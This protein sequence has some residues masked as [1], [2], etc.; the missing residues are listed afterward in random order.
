MGH[1]ATIIYRTKFKELGVTSVPLKYEVS[2]NVDMRSLDMTSALE[3]GFEMFWNSP[4]LQDGATSPSMHCTRWCLDIGAAPGII[5]QISSCVAWSVEQHLPMWWGIRCIMLSP[6]CWDFC[7]AELTAGKPFSKPGSIQILFNWDQSRFGDPATSWMSQG[8]PSLTYKHNV[9]F[10]WGPMRDMVDGSLWLFDA[11]EALCLWKHQNGPGPWPW[12][13]EEIKETGFQEGC[14][15]RALHR[16]TRA[17]TV[18]RHKGTS[19]NRVAWLSTIICLDQNCHQWLSFYDVK[20]WGPTETGINFLVPNHTPRHYPM[21]F[22]RAVADQTEDFKRTRRGQPELPKDLPAAIY[23]FT[24]LE[25]SESDV[26]GMAGLP[27]LY[28]Y[29]RKSKS[30]EI[31]Q[32][33]RPHFPKDL[34]DVGVGAST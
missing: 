19:Q 15:C 17:Q 29:L 21:P 5:T 2:R 25:W 31:P 27:E 33:W 16:Q 12:G 3:P 9:C 1:L 13:V 7:V 34:S 18:Q 30:V 4:G 14:H 32:E 20:I 6:I 23:T 26:W 8:P 10:H 28:R 11:K 24:K 22:A